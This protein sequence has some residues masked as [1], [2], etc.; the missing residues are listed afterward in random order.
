MTILQHRADEVSTPAAL[1]GKTAKAWRVDLETLFSNTNSDLLNNS[2]VALWVIECAWAH[3]IWHSYLMTLIHLRPLAHCS[4]G[5]KFYLHGATHEMWI[6]AL[7]PDGNR[8]AL[9]NG[10]PS[11]EVCPMLTPINF[12]AQFI[13]PGDYQAIVRCEKAIQQICDGL[14]SP[15]TDQQRSWIHLFGNNMVVRK[16]LDS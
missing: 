6:H 10:R 3:P 16:L 8:Q 7:D 14:L 1:T 5:V 2:A 15:D 11:G 12:A 9:I 4:K 13:E